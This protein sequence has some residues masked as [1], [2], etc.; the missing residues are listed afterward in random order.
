MKSRMILTLAGMVLVGSMAAQAA[1]QHRYSFNTTNII[2]S[3]GTAD[4]TI[5]GSTYAVSGGVLEMLN[6]ADY[7]DLPAATIG[8]NTYTELTL[9]V[10]AAT[11]PSTTTW[12]TLLGFGQ[13]NNVDAN[14][15]GKY[16]ILQAARGDDVTRVAISTSMPNPFS[17]EDVVNGP[18]Y[19]DGTNHC[20]AATVNNAGIMALYIDGEYQ[21]DVTLGTAFAS[22]S[23]ANISTEFARI[24]FGYPVDGLWSGAIDELRIRND[25]LSA[26]ELA[27]NNA[28]GPNDISGDPG[29]LTNAFVSVSETNVITE[30]TGQA[31][32]TLEYAIGTF[33]LTK[34]PAL[35][36][37]SSD[38]SVLTI[39]DAGS[40][41]GVSDGF[42]TVTATWDGTPYMSVNINVSSGT[43]KPITL[44][45]WWDFEE[46]SGNSVTDSVA[47]AVGTI[48]NSNF[49][50]VVGDDGG[51][52]LFGGAASQDYDP[53][54]NPSTNNPG[55]FID[56][57]NG[58]IS[59][60]SNA[61]TIEV[62]YE[63]DDAGIWQRVW[64]F[65]IADTYTENEVGLAGPDIFLASTGASGGPRIAL[66][67]NDP[68][69][70]FEVNW[71]ALDATVPG[72]LMH[73]VWTYDSDDLL[74]KMY[75][76]GN[77][78]V[79]SALASNAYHLSQLQ[80]LNNWI[81]RAQYGGD[82]LFNGKIYDLRI[83]NGIMTAAE[84]A[85]R[86]A[87]IGGGGVL[88]PYAIQSISVAGGNVTLMWDSQAGATYNI[89]SK[90][91]LGAA[92]TTNK[93]GIASAGDGT[94]SDSVPVS[95]D[96]EEFF[97]IEGE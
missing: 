97:A 52:D 19:T 60:L 70:S 58:I 93:S 88:D 71:N 37:T 15:M 50:W 18:E 23:L 9:E 33:D 30:T 31:T 78:D 83:Y 42:A 73:V 69:Y 36:W 96:P 40:Y 3:V 75:V 65:G 53:S 61:A 54:F 63:A 29:T 14:W 8:I 27:V 87:E 51:V 12:S 49:A 66:S 80:D 21:G 39:T 10:W 86:W 41:L 46:G 1:L 28:L 22:N 81:G 89:L 84:V 68:G 72:K 17:F 85:A 77:Q 6:G 94:T 67:T 4:G 74:T 79:V 32:L 57:P 13:T 82:P 62:V 59:G 91:T 64:D 95:G 20:Y 92:W 55:S 2:D 35:T 48:V 76:N 38:E 45:Y 44:K 11:A 16:L 25:A 24:G 90:S 5:V 43:P 34:D 7:V 47:G 26:F 56:L